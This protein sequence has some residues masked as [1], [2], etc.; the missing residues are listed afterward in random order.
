[1]ANDVLYE[2]QKKMCLLSPK[3]FDISNFI[4]FAVN[5]AK[6]QNFG[7]SDFGQIPTEFYPLGR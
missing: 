3:N 6:S 2:Q 1:M 4:N 7:A 5:E